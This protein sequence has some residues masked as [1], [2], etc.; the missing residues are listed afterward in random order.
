MDCLLLKKDKFKKKKKVMCAARDEIDKSELGKTPP[1]K[2]N[3]LIVSWRYPM[4]Y[5]S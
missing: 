5:Q 1:K 2:K 4:R 3:H